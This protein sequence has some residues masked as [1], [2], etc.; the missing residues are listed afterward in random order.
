[1]GMKK[2]V[3][4][5]SLL[6]IIPLFQGIA[7]SESINDSYIHII[8]PRGGLYFYGKKL[9]PGYDPFWTV[10]IGSNFIKV[11]TDSSSNILTA[12][13]TLYDIVDKEVIKSELDSTPSNGF[14]CNFSDVPKGRYLTA[15]IALAVDLDEP[16]ASDWRT[17]IFFIPM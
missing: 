5:V 15:V 4:V 16:V 12:Y 17:P 2:L 10:I 13:F 1:M 8:E 14:S 11:D 3:I 9:M 7:V 6:F